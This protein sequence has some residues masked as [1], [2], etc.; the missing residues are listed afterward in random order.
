MAKGTIVV[1]DKWKGYND[2]SSLGYIYLTVD[3]SKNFI[4]PDNGANTQRIE[5]EWGVLKRKLRARGITNREELL[6]YFSEFCAKKHFNNNL[7]KIILKN[8]KLSE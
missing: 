6:L 4:N 1:T 2:C 8:I 5:C 7:L 3:H